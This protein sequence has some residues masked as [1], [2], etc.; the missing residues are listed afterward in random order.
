MF[1]AADLQVKKLSGEAKDQRWRSWI[2]RPEKN[3]VTN[4]DA[5]Y[6]V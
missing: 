1:S 5:V 3:K 4:Y 2:I 6:E